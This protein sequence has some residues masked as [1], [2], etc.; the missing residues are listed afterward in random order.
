MNPALLDVMAR[1]GI[2]AWGAP[3]WLVIAA[4]T[5]AAVAMCAALRRERG[6]PWPAFDEAQAVGLQRFDLQ[7]GA[8]LLLRGTVLLSLLAVFAAPS[9]VHRAPPRPGEGLDLVLVVDASGSMRALDTRVDGE[10][11]TRLDLAREVVARFARQRAAAGDRVGLVVFGDT[12]FTQSPLTSDGRLLTAALERVTA[13]MAGEATALGDALALAVRRVQGADTTSGEGR[14]IVLLTDGRH[15]SGQLT[16]TTAAQLA[17]TSGVR[18]HTVGIGSTGEAVAMAPAAGTARDGLDFERVDVDRATLEA[19]AATTGG[20]SYA[21]RDSRDLASIYAEIDSLERS[22]RQRPPR[23][24][25]TPRPEP[26]LAIAG[27][28]LCLEILLA[29]ALFRRAP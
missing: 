9:G 18:V 23:L 8:A 24:R 6:V 10:W 11:R 14:V 4:A 17:M 3:H 26:L 2:D 22:V 25:H 27:A 15:N 1:A 7:R 29:R 28:L 19:I 13:G 16:A 5:A 21:A 12:A 20:R